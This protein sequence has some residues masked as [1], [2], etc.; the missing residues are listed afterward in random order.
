MQNQPLKSRDPFSE[1][2]LSSDL[3]DDFDLDSIT[4]DKAIRLSSILSKQKPEITIRQPEEPAPSDYL[5]NS[6][7][8][9]QLLFP[10]LKE[11][12][13]EQLTVS[14]ANNVFW[15]LPLKIGYHRA[16]SDLKDEKI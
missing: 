10:E 7:H 14:S 9:L 16:N 6:I 3:P 8:D 1:K 13:P 11:I 15:L 12:N 4:K 2:E 5:V